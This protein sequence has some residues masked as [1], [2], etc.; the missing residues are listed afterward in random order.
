MIFSPAYV[1]AWQRWRPATTS[2]LC[3]SISDWSTLRFSN[4]PVANLIF[5]KSKQ[6]GDILLMGRTPPKTGEENLAMSMKFVHHKVADNKPTW[7]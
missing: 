3:C 6:R 5:K 7:G 4:G 1:A 2:L